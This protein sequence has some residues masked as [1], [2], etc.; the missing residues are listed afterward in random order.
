MEYNPEVLPLSLLL[1]LY[2]ESID[3]TSVNQQGNDRGSQY[4]TGIYYTNKEDL[5]LIRA[6][7]TK[8]EGQYSDYLAVEV[9][10]LRNFYTAEE[11]HQ[12]YLDK[13]PT[14]YCHLPKAL[15]DHARK[16]NDSIAKPMQFKRATT[17]ELKSK[18]TALQYEVTQ[19]E[20]TERPFEN[21]YNKEFRPGIYVD[22][23]TGEP[24]FLSSDKFESGCGWP[25]F[26]KPIDNHLL[27][28]STDTSHG[29]VRSEVKSKKGNAHLGH[30]F[31]DGP[32]ETGGL[33]YCINSASLRFI[34]KEE[35]E[36]EGYGAYI[37]LITPSKPH[38]H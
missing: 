33:R 18:L 28:I 16:T 7:L 25:A 35:M 8:L 27:N 13:N 11:Y 15:F 5:P 10:P 9:L 32:T 23:T 6:E 36:K 12:N 31:E 34:P 14:G 29:M 2:F 3:P 22:I 19:H 24:L 20:A 1:Q 26:S 4:R 30:V 17:E 38:Q 37:K 21:E